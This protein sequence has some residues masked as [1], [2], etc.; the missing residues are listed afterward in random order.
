MTPEFKNAKLY[1]CTDGEYITHSDWSDAILEEMER[2]WEKDETIQEQCERIGPITVHAY[3]ATPVS[4]E[5]I[6]SEVDDIMERFED[7]FNEAHG[8]DGHE[9]EPWTTDTHAWAKKALVANLTKS[10]RSAVTH[11]CEEV[12]SHTFTVAECIHIGT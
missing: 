6:D 11:A 4:P 12:G 7:R 8:C 2:D 3:A 1:T 10:L 9:A 5:W